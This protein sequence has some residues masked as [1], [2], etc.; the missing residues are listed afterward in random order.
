MT[1]NVMMSLGDF[2]FEISTLS[3]DSMKHKRDA[4]FAISE[5]LGAD[6]AIQYMGP[7]EEIISLSGVGAFGIT[8]AER[9]FFTI[10]AMML[11]GEAYDL[12]DNYGN[13]FGLYIIETLDVDRSNFRRFGQAR[14]HSWS[15]NLRRAENQGANIENQI[16]DEVAKRRKLRDNGL[17]DPFSILG[18]RNLL[19]IDIPEI[20]L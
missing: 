4:R 3:Y 15:I 20:G 13:R 6:D 16:F 9:S 10:N 1:H 17:L 8:D 19:P 11:A 18:V 5:R 7:G 12:I 2:L 14:N